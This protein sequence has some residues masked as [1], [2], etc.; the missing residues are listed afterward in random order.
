MVQTM[1]GHESQ[2]IAIIGATGL[3]GTALYHILDDKKY[4]I[5]VVGRS[6]AKLRTHFR[7]AHK[8]LTWAEFK[9]SN[10]M[11]YDVI[12]NLAGASVSAEKWTTEYKIVM[13][14]SRIESTRM[15]TEKCRENPKIRLINASAVSVY[16]FYD[17]PFIAFNESNTQE[18]IGESFL[19][20]L[21]ERW[22]QTA[23]EAEKFGSKVTLLRTGVVFD[24]D[25]GAL[26]ALMKPFR[27]FMGGRIGSGQQMISW[28]SSHDLARIIVFLINRTELTGP[29][30]CVSPGALANRDFAGVLGQA[31][32]KPSILPTPAFIIRAAMGQMGDEL[33]VRGQHVYPQ[34]LNDAGFTFTHASLRHYLSELFAK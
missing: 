19:Q 6:R 29:V 17:K 28:I 18:R 9:D 25:E 15:C 24:R 8:H 21:V 12:V 34:K 1:Q 5:S 22:E 2:S 30:N 16:G 32:H 26:P 14:D 13:V 23:L 4:Q 33:I 10:A 7:K 3:V 20:D 31:M 27:W 11:D